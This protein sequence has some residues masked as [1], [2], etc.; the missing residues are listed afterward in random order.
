M[1]RF[2]IP[3]LLFSLGII[4]VFASVVADYYTNGNWFARSGSILT[5]TSVLSNFI[6]TSVKRKE[7]VSILESGF[8]KKEKAS[9]IKTKDVIY[10]SM[11]LIAFTLGLIGTIIWG[12]GDLV[13]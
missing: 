1:K 12:Y 7:I 3:I 8:D 13:F 6:I 10:K 9:K 4:S 11:Q 5:F 2:K